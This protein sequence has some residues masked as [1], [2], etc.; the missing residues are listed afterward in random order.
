MYITKL[1]GHFHNTGIKSYRHT[2]ILILPR[3]FLNAKRSYSINILNKE[4]FDFKILFLS[5]DS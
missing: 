4:E 2:G 3:N 5:F 1:S